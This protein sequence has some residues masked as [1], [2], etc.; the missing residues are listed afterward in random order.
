METAKWNKKYKNT[1]MYMPSTDVNSPT[2]SLNSHL[3]INCEFSVLWIYSLANLQVCETSISLMS[4]NVCYPNMTW[5]FFPIKST[6]TSGVEISN[7]NTADFFRIALRHNHGPLRGSMILIG[8]WLSVNYDRQYQ[9]ACHV[10]FL[11]WYFAS[12]IFIS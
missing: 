5:F 8:R 1:K 11:K 12:K 6:C 4:A 9:T 10:L 7:T 3:S 2:H